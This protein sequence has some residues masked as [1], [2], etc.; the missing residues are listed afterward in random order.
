MAEINKDLQKAIDDHLKRLYER[1]KSNTKVFTAAIVGHISLSTV[2]VISIL[3][4]FLYLQIDARET[5]SEL[6]RLSQGIAQQEQRAA[7]YRQALTG[8]KKV[9]EAVENAPKPLESY[10]Q[11]LE[12][13]A[14]GGPAAFMP[15]GLKPTPE[16]CGSNADKDRWM[17][18]RIRQ[19][20]AA[21]AAQY[22]DILAREIAAPLEKLNIKEFDQWKADLQA[23]MKRQADRFRTEMTANPGFWRDFNQNAPIYKNMI[24]GAHRFYADHHF[25]EIGRRM[26]ESSA[27]RRAEV[28]QLNQKKDQIQKSKEGLN[29]AL[30]NIKTRFG[31]LGLEVDDAILLAPLALAALF[32]VAALQ[33]CQNIQLRKSF[34]RLFQASDPQKVAITDAEIALAM[35]LWVEPL[36]PPIQR[37]VKLAALMIP[38]IASALTLLVVFYCW[39]IPDAFAGL[40]GIDYVKYIFYYLLSAGFFIYG[41]QRTRRAIKN[42]GASSSLTELITEA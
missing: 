24:E 8:L 9:F 17:E 3:L 32:F 22:Q 13:E 36:A 16:S 1:Y 6:E 31:K 39:T 42:Y 33:L 5:N 26:E 11:A 25:E 10:I 20:M 40:T 30:K 34:H 7:A 38:A 23:G 28:D 2:F 19:Y 35:P 12:K 37:K 27:A 21:R 4:P 18:C 29:N 14:V 15:D 41:F